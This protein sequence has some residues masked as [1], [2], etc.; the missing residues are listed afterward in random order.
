M[1]ETNF[2]VSSYTVLDPIAFASIFQLNRVA[3]GTSSVFCKAVHDGT[4][5]HADKQDSD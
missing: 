4:V 3:R 2:A 5:P 1:G